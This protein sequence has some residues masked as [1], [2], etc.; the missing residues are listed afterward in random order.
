MSRQLIDF[1]CPVHGHELVLCFEL[2]GDETN[3]WRHYYF[4]CPVS[5][6][7]Y[8]AYPNG[9]GDCYPVDEEG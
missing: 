4:E 3:T 8:P 9:L 6:H 7:T 2:D 1:R 5:G